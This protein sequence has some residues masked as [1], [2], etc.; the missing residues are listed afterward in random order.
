MVES[1]SCLPSI[2]S[3][4]SLG[5]SRTEG[6][7]ARYCQSF[8]VLQAWILHFMSP[9]DFSVLAVNQNKYLTLPGPN[10][11]HLRPISHL[12]AARW[13]PLLSGERQS[14]L[15]TWRAWEPYYTSSVWLWA[16]AWQSRA[17]R[18]WLHC[19]KSS[20]RKAVKNRR[21]CLGRYEVPCCWRCLSR[22]W[23]TAWQWL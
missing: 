7:W 16:S 22:C 23:R 8:Q 3:S 2:C 9:P 13:Q 6:S 14:P 1:G 19:R 17:R 5:A 11:I 20:I 4:A 21:S 10:T 15:N 18:F 12:C